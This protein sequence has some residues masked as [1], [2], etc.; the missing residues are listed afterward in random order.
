MKALIWFRFYGIPGS[1]KAE[2]TVP[3]MNMPDIQKSL[4]KQ[5]DTEIDQKILNRLKNPIPQIFYVEQMT[6]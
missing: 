2:I 6:C 1:I 5:V 3:S 4:Q